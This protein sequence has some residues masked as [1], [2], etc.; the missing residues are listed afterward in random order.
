[1]KSRN[2]I[3]RLRLIALLAKLIIPPVNGLMEGA[4]GLAGWWAGGLVGWWAGG[5]V[6]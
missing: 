1:M 2:T 3:S 5:L 6:G 4:G